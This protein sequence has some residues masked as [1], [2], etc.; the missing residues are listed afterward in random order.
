ME[1]TPRAVPG[2]IRCPRRWEGQSAAP[3]GWGRGKVPETPQFSPVLPRL[4]SASF[5][6]FFP[7]NFPSRQMDKKNLFK[8]IRSI[9]SIFFP[10]KIV[11]VE[12]SPLKAKRGNLGGYRVV[13]GLLPALCRR[14]C[15]I[16][17]ATRS[18]K[19]FLL[20]GICRVKQDPVLSQLLNVIL[21][22]CLLI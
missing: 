19:A 7:L 2:G 5:S 17:P 9:F 18:D 14:K 8:L 10:L 3:R 4:T 1:E 22:L 20:P 12:L 16:S 13:L 11:E 21:P 6:A 15:E